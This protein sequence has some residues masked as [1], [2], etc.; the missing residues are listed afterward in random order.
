MESKRAAADYA[1]LQK[2]IYAE[3][4]IFYATTDQNIKQGYACIFG[5]EGTPY[6]DCPM[7]YS[8]DIGPSYPFDP[9]KVQ[10]LTYDGHTRFHPN[11]YKE[12]KVCLSIL[13]TWDG[14]KWAS[15]M[16]LSTIFLTLQSIMDTKP[17]MHEPGYAAGLGHVHHD[18]AKWIEYC[19]MQYTIT[20]AITVQE[21]KSQPEPFKPFI[22][23][24]KTFL[25]GILERFERRLRNILIET[26]GEERV[27]SALPYSMGGKTSYKKLLDT[28]VALRAHA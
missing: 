19:C 14:P 17:L 28:V 8:V 13:H 7:L 16:R 25:P 21:G 10:F 5:P 3:A 6:E 1:E 18:Y 20:R 9:P 11:M 26:A 23:T 4:R 2:P 27:Y 12:G 22:E 15:T 24:F